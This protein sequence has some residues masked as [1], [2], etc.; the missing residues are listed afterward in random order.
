MP[1]QKAADKMKKENAQKE[2]ILKN[3]GGILK[4]LDVSEMKEEKARKE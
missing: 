2:E 4:V 1:E 3:R